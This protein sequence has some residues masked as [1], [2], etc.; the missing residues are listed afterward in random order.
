MNSMHL[1]TGETS[2]RRRLPL[3]NDERLD[4]RRRD[5]MDAV[6][7]RFENL[8]VGLVTGAAARW[9]LSV[10]IDLQLQDDLQLQEFE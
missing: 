4:Q 3:A 2:R 10:D 5:D 6:S 7:A 1:R 9:N 8:Q